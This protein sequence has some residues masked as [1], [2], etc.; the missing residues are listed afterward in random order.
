METDCPSSMAKAL[1]ISGGYFSK[2]AELRCLRAKVFVGQS[3]R[4][5]LGKLH[6]VLSKVF[7]TIR[8]VYR[9]SIVGIPI[10][11]CLQNVLTSLP[12]MQIQLLKDG[13]DAY[14][15]ELLYREYN[16]SN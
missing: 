15:R 12:A 5:G 11:N 4:G 10:H 16:G 1:G 14:D 7:G 2:A 13:S 3:N 9:E 8:F 6:S